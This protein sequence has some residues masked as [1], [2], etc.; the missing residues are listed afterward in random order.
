MFQHQHLMNTRNP[1]TGVNEARQL[2][3][4]KFG[5]LM[6]ESST[7]ANAEI[8]AMEQQLAARNGLRSGARF[9]GISDIILK[10]VEAT[11]DKAIAYRREL[12]ASIPALLEENGM[13]PLKDRLEKYVDGSVNGIRQRGTMLPRGAGTAS[14][15]QKIQQKAYAIKARLGRKLA[16]LPLE[17]KLGLLKEEP[18]VTTLNISNSTIANLNL[19]NV[20]GDLNSSIQQLNTGGHAELAEA[21]FFAARC[22]DSPNGRSC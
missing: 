2:A 8:I 18:K 6:V 19:G 10:S 3:E 17:A 14:V 11:V 20:V 21:L 4:I 9:K 15:N 22:R 12:G 5:E 7:T 16:V 1:N 13:K